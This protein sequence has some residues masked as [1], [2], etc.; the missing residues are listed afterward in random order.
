MERVRGRLDARR[1]LSDEDFCLLEKLRSAHAARL[2]DPRQRAKLKSQVGV[3]AKTVE[4]SAMGGALKRKRDEADTADAD[5]EEEVAAQGQVDYAVDPETLAPVG[6]TVRSSKVERIKLMLAGRKEDR[7]QHDGHAGGL[8]NKE[9]QRKKN[10]VMVRKGK[11][12]L[13]DKTRR[14]NSQQR[15]D[16]HKKNPKVCACAPDS[17][18]PNYP[19]AHALFADVLFPPSNL[20]ACLGILF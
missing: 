15:Y 13:L 20:T 19:P 2:L 8:T 11:R 5:G 10:F 17:T 14:S 4:A 7:F 12:A 6:R 18:K 16:K 1:V 9:K 3:D